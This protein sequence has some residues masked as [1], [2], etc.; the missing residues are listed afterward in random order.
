MMGFLPSSSGDSSHHPEVLPPLDCSP[1]GVCVGPWIAVST[2]DFRL[3]RTH[4][5]VICGLEMA[6]VNY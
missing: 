2:I 6:I 5:K 3:M 1:V 4:I